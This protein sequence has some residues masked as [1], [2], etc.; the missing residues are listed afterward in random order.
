MRSVKPQL[1]S[2]ACQ[3]PSVDRIL[4]PIIL[5]RPQWEKKERNVAFLKDSPARSTLPPKCA[6]GRGPHED[7]PT[8]R[9][10]TG[11]SN[12]SQ[13]RMPLVLFPFGQPCAVIQA[14]GRGSEGQT[15]IPSRDR[16]ALMRGHGQPALPVAA[17]LPENLVRTNR[18]P[19]IWVAASNR[20]S[21]KRKARG[22]LGPIKTKLSQTR[23]KQ[24]R[25]GGRGGG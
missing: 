2:V 22:G 16:A 10:K 25:S 12:R 21:H 13:R 6:V 9:T 19:W 3:P 20:T 8:L 4:P 5:G 1:P 14:Q 15:G 7:K 11:C 17:G 23:F 18:G 24:Y